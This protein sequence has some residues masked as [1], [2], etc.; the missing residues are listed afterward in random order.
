MGKISNFELILEIFG[1]YVPNH[2]KVDLVKRLIIDV[3]LNGKE[4]MRV[5]GCLQNGINVKGLSGGQRRRLSLVSS[6]E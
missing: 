1:A 5:G 6:R 2:R 4:N 3:G